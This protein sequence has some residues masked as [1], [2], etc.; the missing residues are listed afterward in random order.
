MRNK[1]RIS[2]KR[3]SNEEA[4]EKVKSVD[5]FLIKCKKKETGETFFYDARDLKEF[6]CGEINKV[7]AMFI[8]EKYS[9]KEGLRGKKS[10]QREI[11][12]F[13]EKQGIKE[14]SEINNEILMKYKFLIDE[15]K[16]LKIKTKQG[17]YYEMLSLLNY[18]ALKGYLLSEDVKNGDI[19]K[20]FKGRTESQIEKNSKSADTYTDRE[21]LI[22]LENSIKI[23]K[24]I[25][26]NHHDK[27]TAF[28]VVIALLSGVNA[29]VLLDFTD[30]DLEY[31][32][33]KRDFYEIVKYKGRKGSDIKIILKD[34]DLFKSS[35][36]DL[37]KIVLDSKRKFY[38]DYKSEYFKD[39]LF[40]YPRLLKGNQTGKWSLLNANASIGQV[41]RMFVRYGIKIECDFNITKSRKYF[42]RKINNITKNES[43][44]ST[45]MGHS[46]KTANKHYLDVVAN[47]EQHQKLALTQDTLKAFSQSD[48]TDNF[49]VY[50][51]LLGLYGMDLSKALDL[52]N[53]GFEIKEIID[54]SQKD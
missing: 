21:Y 49:I 45:L 42:E 50:Q 26:S 27:V 24:D 46:I 8:Q 13:I 32:S 4:I 9:K 3:D 31:L 25:E 52:A 28:F 22:L 5:L 23:I 37:S 38:F 34:Y 48:Q 2:Y 35:I 15:T 7:S 39:Y 6:D 33:K 43:I 41:K 18:A 36:S 53:K 12:S 11:L 16:D 29:S 30:E 44:T 1:K 47:E 54:K 17:K 19:P 10:I 51:K 20:N 14:F 40:I